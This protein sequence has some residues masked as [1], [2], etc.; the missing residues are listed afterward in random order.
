MLALVSFD[1]NV[2]LDFSVVLS[3][4]IKLFLLP[5]RPAPPPPQG[6]ILQSPIVKLII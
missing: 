6:I 2:E 1:L 4:V 5:I 3:L